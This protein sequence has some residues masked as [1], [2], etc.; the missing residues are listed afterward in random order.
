MPG[1]YF[2]LTMTHELNILIKCRSSDTAYLTAQSPV[3]YS[4]SAGQ[5]YPQRTSRSTQKHM[6]YYRANNITPHAWTMPEPSHA[7]FSKY[8]TQEHCLF[9]FGDPFGQAGTVPDDGKT[10]PAP[11]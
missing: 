8:T 2:R 10:A 6:Y 9:S 1:N 3:F 11:G 4:S 7:Y 5:L